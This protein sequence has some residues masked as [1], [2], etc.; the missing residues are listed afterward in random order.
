MLSEQVLQVIYCLNQMDSLEDLVWKD[1]NP[2]H[3][4]ALDKLILSRKLKYICGPTGIEVP[5][6]NYYIVRPCVNAM[7]LGLG[8][9]KMFIEKITEHLPLGYFWCEWFEGKH[10]SIDYYKGEVSLVVEGHK[11]EDTF[12][13]WS[14][15][16]KVNDYIEFPKILKDFKN[17]EWINCEFIGGKLIEVHFRRNEDFQWN[18]SVFIPVFDKNQKPPSEKYTYVSYPENNGRIG[19]FINNYYEKKT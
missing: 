5:K 12:T 7:G 1:V 4:W 14:K 18:N 15:W 17:F 10:L 13:K 6:P 2:N 16:E 8:A 3:L 19:G 9:E 11:S